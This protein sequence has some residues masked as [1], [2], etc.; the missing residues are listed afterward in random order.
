[1][2]DG[3]ERGKYCPFKR[4]FT[5]LYDKKLFIKVRTYNYPTDGK[6]KEVAILYILKNSCSGI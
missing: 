5:K 3:E 1:M 6:E 2:Q 4:K